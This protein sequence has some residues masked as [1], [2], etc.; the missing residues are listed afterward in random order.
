MWRVRRC[1]GWQGH[2]V[3]QVRE[4]GTDSVN[5][6]LIASRIM[7]AVV[8][9]ADDALRGDKCGSGKGQRQE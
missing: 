6:R 2:T 9:E 7:T 5:E 4:L 1:F 3:Q 8:A